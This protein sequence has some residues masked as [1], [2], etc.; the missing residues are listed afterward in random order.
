M[1]AGLATAI[2]KI[3]SIQTKKTVLLAQLAARV[4]LATREAERGEE[5]EP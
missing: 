4:D 2:V 5:S 3:K 1:G